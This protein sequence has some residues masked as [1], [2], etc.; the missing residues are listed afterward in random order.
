MTFARLL[1][2]KANTT[3]HII[4]RYTKNNQITSGARGGSKGKLSEET[5]EH[6]LDSLDKNAFLS[7]TQMV[8]SVKEKNGTICCTATISNFLHGQ[9]ISFKSTR[10]HV[11]N[12]NCIRVQTLR[13]EYV[14]KFLIQNWRMRECIYIDEC[15]FNLWLRSRKG[16]KKSGERLNV[17]VPNSRGPNIS[18]AL[19]IA[20]N[21]PVYYKLITGSFTKETYGSFIQEVS[22]KLNLNQKYYFIQDN[23]SIHG[24]AE[25]GNQ[26]HIMV[27]LP[28]YSPFLNPIESVFSKL[29]SR[30]RKQMCGNID[31]GTTNVKIQKMMDIIGV[32]IGKPDYQDLSAYFRHVREFFPA[33]LEMEDIYGD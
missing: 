14:K 9:M 11:E 12:K 22:G 31:T 27:N 19:A 21:G 23:A 26:N 28:P 15:S 29:K 8:D 5:K 6:I 18:L 20:K 32:E 24:N 4:N 7:L 30:I 2:I 1:G 16:W 33:S 17:T 10:T 3:R 13:K 25:T